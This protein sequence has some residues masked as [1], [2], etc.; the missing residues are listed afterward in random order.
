MERAR[1]IWSR[2]C[3]KLCEEANLSKLAERVGRTFEDPSEA[4]QAAGADLWFY[5]VLACEAAE[6]VLDLHRDVKRME[7]I[8]SWEP[9]I[10][11][12]CDK[13]PLLG[14]VLNCKSD[15]AELAVSLEKA[16]KMLDS[17][18]WLGLKLSDWEPRCGALAASLDRSELQS[19]RDNHEEAFP[20]EH[21]GIES[22]YEALRQAS[23]EPSI[24]AQLCVE[25]AHHSLQRAQRCMRDERDV[26]ELLQVGIDEED[27][28]A[29]Q[30]QSL[31]EAS[32]GVIEVLRREEQD[33]LVEV[34]SVPALLSA[35]SLLSGENEPWQS[36]KAL[37][38]K[39][40]DEG[41]K[42]LNRLGSL[43]DAAESASSAAE[44]WRE[45]LKLLN[46]SSESDEPSEEEEEESEAPREAFELLQ[47][48]ES[49][50]EQRIAP[51]KIPKQGLRP[52]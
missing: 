32:N 4:L 49:E 39:G 29:K 24:S 8:S 27:H 10:E 23:I 22:S 35:Q 38:L 45:A 46:K 52:W 16:L 5:K 17:R 6:S 40:K 13:E 33:L 15:A 12:L 42:V 18:A 51:S 30:M 47:Q 19:L 2:G 21:P 37:F 34:E 48:M 20:T 41:R 3:Q 31:N 36:A 9:R 28:A 44:Y 7:K 50:D 14:S 25:E 11:A 26:K 1:D 43:S